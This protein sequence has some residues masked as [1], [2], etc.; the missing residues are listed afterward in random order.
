[1]R[2]HAILVSILFA[3]AAAAAKA[4][5]ALLPPPTIEAI[6][7]TA[8][9]M[10]SRVRWLDRQNL[11]VEITAVNEEAVFAHN[12]SLSDMNVREIGP[13]GHMTVSPGG[14]YLLQRDGSQWFV[15]DLTKS[16][17]AARSLPTEV[18]GAAYRS[19][20]AWS[21]D[22]R[23][24]AFTMLSRINSL[25]SQHVVRERNSAQYI[26]VGADI[27]AKPRT[28]T[29]V[30][31]VDWRAHGAKPIRLHVEGWITDFTW[32]ADGRLYY[33][34][35]ITRDYGK[36]PFT[37]VHAFDPDTSD[38]S[39]IYQTAG[40][41]YTMFPAVSPDGRWLAVAFDIDHRVWND[42]ISL[43][44]VDLSTG[45]ER[46]LTEDLDIGGGD[47]VWA[48]DSD[49]LYFTARHG[50]Y[51]RI[52]R[53]DLNGDVSVVSGG[54]R[55]HSDL[56][57][58][59]DGR[60]LSYQTMDGYGRKDIRVRNLA[61]GA[62]RIAWEIDD[63]TKRFTLGEFQRIQWPNGEGLEISGFLVFPPDFDP[64][65]KYP[66]FTDVHGGGGG[67]HL[68]LRA[69]FT[70]V[71]VRGPLEWHA[72][73]AL[74]YVVFV[75]DYRSTG[76]YGPASVAARYAAGDGNGVKGDVKDI[77]SGVR[78]IVD[79]GYIDETRLAIRGYSAG[80]ARVN[81]LLTETDMFSAATLF[82][83]TAPGNLTSLIY[84]ITGP[85]TG[86][87]FEDGQYGMF[88]NAKLAEAPERY[89]D[90]YLLDGYKYKTPT[91]ILV[92][93]EERNANSSISEEALFSVLREYDIPTRMLRFVNEGH[94]FR[95]PNSVMLAFDEMLRWLEA[96]MPTQDSHS[97]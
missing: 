57:I 27:D 89:Y 61:D 2:V 3:A 48:D 18:G 22:E 46:R 81:A 19:Q 66:L 32:G 53:V 65:K 55:K 24:I 74:G 69:P 93:A 83:P 26:D 97:H 90:G 43:V 38:V 6:I 94:T 92:G 29:D 8:P 64:A 70:H 87:L 12:V 25:G 47:Y 91:L 9:P 84:F 54:E 33:T 35:V 51:D 20:P 39:L 17:A 96:H 85:N 23:F 86:R 1:M 63:P 11:A 49:A 68:F 52:H 72:L 79:Q 10:V 37:S 4:D 71:V 36:M 41:F 58:S 75:P 59:P 14:S 78:H 13:G 45:A 44:L 56:Q 15:S 62:E 77:E 76:T 60:M 73:A 30:L 95:D 67:S 31:I 16:N 5:E 50:G 82:E 42:F 21:P 88:L 40:Q 7:E 80:G 28:T 34:R